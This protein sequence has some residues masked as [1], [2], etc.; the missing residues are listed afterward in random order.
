M[1]FCD[2][3]ANRLLMFI[4]AV[5]VLVGLV[6]LIFGILG[7]LQQGEVQ[8]YT[9]GQDLS[10]VCIGVLVVGVII[11][12]VGI[13]GWVAGFKGNATLAKGYVLLILLIVILQLAFCLIGYFKRGSL[14]NAA[15]NYLN[16]TFNATAYN[17]LA[18]ADQEIVDLIQTK[19][20]CCG[21]S[22][23]WAGDLPASC[24]PSFNATANAT[25]NATVSTTA[26]AACSAD[27]AFQTGCVEAAEGF[28]VGHIMIIV[29]VL[30][31]GF[32]L[33]LLCMAAGCYIAKEVHDYRRV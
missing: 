16:A 33:E 9:G 15:D 30:A 19:L 10:L 17:S 23:S 27:T 4:N 31:V 20:E 8:E 6:I 13:I 12:V 32:V 25:A 22:G 24:C 5:T 18:P 7:M 21:L 14:K 3:T 2:S 1:G 26:A 11:L 29:I 28:V